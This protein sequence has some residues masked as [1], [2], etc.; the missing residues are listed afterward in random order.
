[1]LNLPTE[2][3]KRIKVTNLSTQ[4]FIVK[5]NKT[6]FLNYFFRARLINGE[7][8]ERRDVKNNQVFKF[9]NSTW[10]IEIISKSEALDL[11]Y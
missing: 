1:M 9:K 8:L 11:V 6:H 4:K 2:R 5:R 3:D 7:L 10:L